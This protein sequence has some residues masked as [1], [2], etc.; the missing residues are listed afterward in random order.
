MANVVNMKRRA[1]YHS[2][3]VILLLLAIPVATCVLWLRSVRRQY[4]LNR[5][6]IAALVKGDDKKALALVNAGADPNTHFEPTP[7]PT[8]PELMRQLFHRSPPPIHDT[9]TAFM[10]ACGADWREDDEAGPAEQYLRPDAPQLPRMMLRHGANVDIGDKD[11]ITPLMWAAAYHRPKT[12]LLLLTH[13]AK[14]NAGD[15]EGMTPLMWA[16]LDH[17]D[18]ETIRLL[19]DHG[20]A[21]NPQEKDG[22]TALCWAVYQPAPPRGQSDG[23]KD[24]VRLL[25][26]YGANPNLP[27]HDGCTPLQIAQRQRRLNLVALLRQAGVKK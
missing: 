3:P 5:Q 4:T 21:V 19:L 23:V 24:I 14:I 12:T 25:L 18:L 1:R 2:V 27:T 9:P 26:A 15:R 20:A 7:A 17:P 22:W 11:G 10:I 6:L 16:A 13:A 8:L